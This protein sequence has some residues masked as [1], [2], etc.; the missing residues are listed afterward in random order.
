MSHVVEEAFDLLDEKSTWEKEAGIVEPIWEL[1][2]VPRPLFFTQAV[3][4]MFEE[5]WT[6]VCEVMPTGN[7]K[8]WETQSL[9][10]PAPVNIEDSRE[11]LFFETAVIEDG[12]SIVCTN[13]MSSFAEAYMQH[14]CQEPHL[15]QLTAFKNNCAEK[16][17]LLAS[18]KKAL[19]KTCRMIQRS[20]LMRS[21][22]EVAASTWFH[23]PWIQ[24]GNCTCK[25]QTYADW[26][27]VHDIINYKRFVITREKAWSQLSLDQ[28]DNLLSNYFKFHEVVEK[29]K[30]SIG[31]F[32]LRE[33]IDFCAHTYMSNLSKPDD[34]LAQVF[35]DEEYRINYC[36]HQYFEH[37]EKEMEKMI[38]NI[39]AFL[40]RRCFKKGFPEIPKPKHNSLNEQTRSL[41]GARIYFFAHTTLGK[42]DVGT[43]D[44]C[45]DQRQ[46][47]STPRSSVHELS[48]IRVSP[49]NSLKYASSTI[50]CLKSEFYD[51]SYHL[52]QKRS[53]EQQCPL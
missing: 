2:Q 40:E 32:R 20:V 21:P 38:I 48:L 37:C 6:R 34:V 4:E 28:R 53:F 45:S 12:K 5:V 3:S 26:E 35:A 33:G 13:F 39:D 10:A 27:I 44:L 51:Q 43:K 14:V 47:S 29:L 19:T 46:P 18:Q 9:G 25:P 8:Y 17:Q 24:E 31:N 7:N 15:E 52:K 42:P 16:L 50:S 41:A 1:R 23:E 22:M 49:Y 11:A 30:L 36:L